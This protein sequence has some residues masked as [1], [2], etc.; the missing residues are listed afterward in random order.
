M[1][2]R[3][4]LLKKEKVDELVKTINED[5]KHINHTSLFNEICKAIANGFYDDKIEQKEKNKIRI[6]VYKEHVEQAREK[7]K[8]LGYG[9]L[10]ELIESVI[11]YEIKRKKGGNKYGK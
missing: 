4:V 8:E 1:E 9:T 6:N 5:D 3:K 7:A 10:S 11:D 2:R